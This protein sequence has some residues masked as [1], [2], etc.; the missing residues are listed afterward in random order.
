MGAEVE[1]VA[2]VGKD[3]FADM[4]LEV[5]GEDPESWLELVSRCENL[6]SERVCRRRPRPSGATAWR[7]PRL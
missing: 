6:V 2:A 3:A 7:G 5:R 4:A 1:F